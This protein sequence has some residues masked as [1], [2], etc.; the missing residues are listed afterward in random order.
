MLAHDVLEF[1][2]IGGDDEALCFGVIGADFAGYGLDIEVLGVAFGGCQDFV[3][4]VFDVVDRGVRGHRSCP[5][6]VGVEGFPLAG[7]DITVIQP[8]GLLAVASSVLL[9]ASALSHDVDNFNGLKYDRC[10]HKLFGE[11]QGL[12]LPSTI[13]FS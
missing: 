12:H 9:S 1:A 3:H 6:G 5:F 13:E 10:D 8:R 11:C 2:I 4:V 7:L